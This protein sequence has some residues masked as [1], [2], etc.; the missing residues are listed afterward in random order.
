MADIY[1]PQRSQ[2]GGG[3]RPRINLPD[4]G[5]VRQVQ[6]QPD[7]GVRVP[8]G[9]FGGGIGA[10]GD[11]LGDAG[12][13][14]AR[15]TQ[16]ELERQQK[17]YDAT[18]TGE[19]ELGFDKVSMEGFSTWQV[20]DDPSNPEA[21]TRLEKSLA[22]Q[23]AEH[24]AKLDKGVSEFARESLTL[25]LR[26]KSQGVLDAARRVSLKAGDDAALAVIDQKT[27]QQSAQAQRDPAYLDTLLKDGDEELKKFAGTMTPQS[28]TKAKVER[29]ANTILGA[30][31]GMANS[32]R[33]TEATTLLA[34]GKYDADLDRVART[35]A[36]AMVESA[37][38][39]RDRAQEKN[40]RQTDKRLKLEGDQGLKDFYAIVG[41]GELPTSA[42]VDR[43][44]RNPGVSPGEYKGVVDAL[45]STAEKDDDA[46]M[47][48]WSPR[49]DSEDLTAEI[50]LAAREHRITTKTA[51][52]QIDK[53]RT[54]RKDDQPA[55]PFKSGRE[56]VSV[57]LDPGQLG[58]DPT[59]RQPLAIARSNA[60]ADFDTFI[61]ANPKID[62]PAA[63]NKA[64]EIVQSYQNVAFDQMRLA[65]PRPRGFTGDKQSIK[66]PDID[67]ARAALVADL[68]AGRLS[69][70]EAGRQLEQ[71]ETW[72]RVI[73]KI[74]PPKPPK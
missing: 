32:G 35:K 9:A 30:I 60:L 14:L 37:R 16:I 11:A 38:A 24:L 8:A 33:F 69:Q 63:L 56:H 40:E 21:L 5:D 65:L 42:D 1:L 10:A 22:G 71:L 51:L 4:A 55:S 6:V 67:A 73:A 53:N 45:K 59:I 64:R 57:S 3:R 36:Q 19:T 58:G 18:R 25:K 66:Q 52:A 61:E 49:M 46:L 20:Q 74:T 15:A 23:E 29:R 62:R 7:P 48:G 34:S 13:R 47:L 31:Q 68:D 28:E 44:R 17:Q 41:G 70:I 2:G 43:L 72:E 26:S 27:N 39:E 12:L 50:S 54:A